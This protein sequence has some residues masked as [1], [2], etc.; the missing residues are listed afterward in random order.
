MGSGV[1]GRLGYSERF[2]GEVRREGNLLCFARSAGSGSHFNGQ[3]RAVHTFLS[4]ALSYL[5]ASS[6]HLMKSDKIQGLQYLASRE[7]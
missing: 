6:Q 3:L 1:R 7:K 4:P 2:G 5:I